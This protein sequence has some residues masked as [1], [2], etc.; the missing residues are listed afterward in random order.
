MQEMS[1][2]WRE[3]CN[4][5]GIAPLNDYCGGAIDGSFVTLNTMRK[6]VRS[7]TARAFLKPAERRP[8]LLILTDREVDRIM[9][10]GKRAIDVS[11][12]HGDGNEVYLARGEV[13]VSAGS[14]G[15]PALLLRSG[16]GP[17]AELSPLGIDP[18]LDLPGVGR[19][20]HDHIAV[21]ISKQ[22][23]SKTYNLDMGPFGKVRSALEYLLFRSGRLASAAVQAMAYARSHPNAPEPDLALNFQPLAFDASVQP[24]RLRDQGAINVS[25]HPTHPRGRGQVRLRSGDFRQ[26]PVIDY[27][28]LGHEYDREMLLKGCEILESIYS[29][30]ALAP[31][32]V[33]GYEPPPRAPASRDDWLAWIRARVGVGWHP[34]GT[35]RMGSDE[36]AVTDPR[37]KLRGIKGLRVVDASVMPRIISGNTNAPTIM[38][39]EKAADMIL[40]DARA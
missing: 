5:R 12:R 35:C 17:A 26:P 10:D 23:L 40:D 25:C 27:P 15:S 30:P 11:A 19:N 28:L 6:G 9:F 1:V 31:Y 22:V 29:A 2:R 37:L 36:L 34:V 4:E 39:A 8:N 18:V 20:L 33:R 16:V 32:V 13:I 7:S 24:P 14:I 21:G 38:I 3:G